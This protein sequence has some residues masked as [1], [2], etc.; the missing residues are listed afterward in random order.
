MIHIFH[1]PIQKYISFHIRNFCDEARFPDWPVGEPL[2]FLRET[3]QRWRAEMSKSVADNAV[4]EAKIILGF[5][6]GKKVTYSDLRRS[7]KNLAR[8]Y[9][10]DKNPNGRPMFEKIRIA[11]DLLSSVELKVTE[12]DLNNVVLLIKTQNIIYRRFPNAV[13]DQKYPAFQFLLSVL[14]VPTAHSDFKDQELDST[15]QSSRPKNS[16]NSVTSE[17]EKEKKI[18]IKKEKEDEDERERLSTI[19]SRKTDG[20][21]N[22]NNDNDIDI[23]NNNVLNDLLLEGTILIFYTCSVSPLNVREFV[24]V[25]GT[26]KLFDIVVYAIQT[27]NNIIE[28]NRNNNY[29]NNYNDNGF[30]NDKNNNS[31][32]NN[33]GS[34]SN[35]NNN[36]N[37]NNNNSNNTTIRK[38]KIA[39][40]LLFYSM[41]SF[42]SIAAFEI[43]RNSIEFLCPRFADEMY[44]LLSFD[45]LIPIAVENCIETISRCCASERLQNYYVNSG[46][47]WKLIPFLLSYDNTL[48]N[49]NNNYDNEL[50]RIVYNQYSCNVHAILSAKCLG[51]LC[52][53]M[54]DDLSS[55]LNQSLIN[56]L[57]KL[58]TQPIAKLL[59][60]RKP[61]QL[62]AALNENVELTTIIWN[63]T[64]RKE[65]LEFVLSIQNNRMEGS[66]ENEMKIADKFHFSALNGELCVCGVYLR[67]FNRT[68]RTVD[69][70]DPSLLAK[71]L[72][73]YVRNVLLSDGEDDNGEGYGEGRGEHM[74]NREED[75]DEDEGEG[76]WKQSIS[77]DGNDK[78]N[79]AT[80]S[81]TNSNNYADNDINNDNKSNNNNN[82]NNNND[83]NNHNNLCNIKIE[84]SSKDVEKSK[85]KDENK[86]KRN[87]RKS[88]DIGGG[89]EDK[90]EDGDSGGFYDASDGIN[91]ATSSFSSS[92]SSSSSSLSF[93]SSSVYKK[94]SHYGLQLSVEAIRTLSDLH[95]YISH[96]IATHKNGPDTVFLL[97]DLPDDSMTF[98]SATH[99]LTS[100]GRSPDFVSLA[101]RPCQNLIY[102]TVKNEVKT[103]MENESE[104]RQIRNEGH[105]QGLGLG[106][107]QEN[108]QGQGLGQGQGTSCLWRLVRAVCTSDSN[109]SSLLWTA[110]ESYISHTDGLRAMLDTGGV[111][112]MLGVLT[113]AIGYTNTFHNRLSAMSLLTKFLNSPVMGSESSLTLR[114][115]LP[116]PLVL[117][118]RNRTAAAALKCLDEICET[119]EIIWTA[120][121]QYELR[122]AVGGVLHNN[123]NN[124]NNND[125][126]KNNNSNKRNNKGNE[127]DI[128]QR[129]NDNLFYNPSYINEN[130][131]VIYRQI[132]NEIYV[133]GVYIRLY[134]KQPMFRLSNSMFFLERLIELWE[135]SFSKQVP[136]ESSKGKKIRLIR[137]ILHF[138]FKFLM[139][140]VFE[141]N[142]LVDVFYF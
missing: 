98:M 105:G 8:Q 40:E 140:T 83:M 20:N 71:D 141:P 91:L 28:N 102:Q 73:D 49:N 107:G 9:H 67:I 58:L 29:N 121:M 115:F 86:G 32:S 36:N 136:S 75:E 82:N 25:G 19:R 137:S 64:M 47:I 135:H 101:L 114:R 95:D 133:G 34:N 4:E 2:T 10:P 39:E 117:L 84:G 94:G 62:L 45:K 15:N 55:P 111:T 124:N 99:L 43:G 35:R 77:C 57:N 31:Y 138:F 65:L 66:R 12:T 30:N 78:K 104:G 18:K 89:R 118:L 131:T 70:D 17:K 23:D 54:F 13:N 74:Y 79:P 51:R 68:A 80:Y 33:N 106:Q 126:N 129:R 48:N 134:M 85:E 3:L 113:G 123:N 72:L 142:L 60:N 100:L 110:A 41:K 21:N 97:L 5:I 38:Q 125:N 93:L 37:N 112:H 88:N 130:F 90:D 1:I 116:E 96:D 14:T 132:E 56:T 22:D 122:L 139:S 50:L 108:G 44:K 119:P 24:R 16:A 27:I 46:T 59:R 103:D 109:T 120:E 92:S 53:V 69:I 11:Y 87:I 52:G 81:Y 127:R 128:R 6:G 76:D 61:F 42:T 7:Y 63:V 26:Q